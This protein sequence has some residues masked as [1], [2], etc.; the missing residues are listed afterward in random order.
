MPQGTKK[1]KLIVYMKKQVIEKVIYGVYRKT[2]AQMSH[3]HGSNH[4][5]N[6]KDINK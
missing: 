2:A 1:K 5:H 3:K 6:S 4:R